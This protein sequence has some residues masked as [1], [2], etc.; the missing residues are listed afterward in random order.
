[1]NL[2]FS[3]CGIN[4]ADVDVRMALRPDLLAVVGNAPVLSPH[5]FRLID[6]RRPERGAAGQ[7]HIVQVVQSAIVRARQG[8]P[9]IRLSWI[10]VLQEEHG[11]IRRLLL[12]F[13][14][15]AALPRAHCFRL[16]RIAEALCCSTRINRSCNHQNGY[17][18][19]HRIAAIILG[20]CPASPP[21]ICSPRPS[22]SCCFSTGLRRPDSSARRAPLRLHRPRD[23][24]FRRLDYPAVSGAKRGLKSLRC[25][26]G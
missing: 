20:S 21:N 2:S 15:K 10:D 4:L 25:C 26:I 7:A 5:R 9:T 19:S 11:L 3:I 1:M 12:G 8:Q 24:C 14:A 22:C 13:P 23:G 6:R 18:K 16:L 17:S